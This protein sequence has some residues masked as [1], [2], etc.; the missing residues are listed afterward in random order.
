MVDYRLKKDR[1]KIK[2]S[3]LIKKKDFDESL[4]YLQEKCFG[5]PLWKSRSRWSLKCEWQVHNVL[6]KLGIK[7]ERTADVDFEFK[8]GKLLQLEY[9][10][11]GSILMII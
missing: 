5:I 7:R 2:N 10:I 11:L 9:I 8:Q 4:D 6:Y 3:Y 1:L